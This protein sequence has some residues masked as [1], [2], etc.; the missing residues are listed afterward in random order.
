MYETKE[1]N[2]PCNLD[3]HIVKAGWFKYKI[4][5]VFYNQHGE[6][7]AQGEETAFTVRE[8]SVIIRNNIF[9]AMAKRNIKR[10]CIHVINHTNKYIK[11]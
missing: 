4:Y 9:W 11:Y 7:Y 8:T 6:N 10:D 2:I 1:K 5:T 3:I